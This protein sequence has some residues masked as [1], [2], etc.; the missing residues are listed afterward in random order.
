MAQIKDPRHPRLS[1]A[2]THGRAGTGESK[3]K[4]QSDTAARPT[5]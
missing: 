2:F 3:M 1:F 4:E 5:L